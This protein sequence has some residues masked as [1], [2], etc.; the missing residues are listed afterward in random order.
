M[1]YLRQI[2]LFFSISI[3]WSESSVEYR[4]EVSWPEGM[5][6]GIQCETGEFDA[7]LSVSGKDGAAELSRIYFSSHML[8]IGPLVFSGSLKHLFCE[9]S[10]FFS[11]E[12]R[13]GCL[14]DKEEN[15]SGNMGVAFSSKDRSAGLA[16]LR[17]E[18][19]SGLYLWF[20]PELLLEGTL[21]FGQSLT[22]PEDM[23]RDESWY[24]AE[25]ALYSP[26]ISNSQFILVLG[27]P[28]LYGG[29]ELIIN[30][31]LFDKGGFSLRLIGGRAGPFWEIRS[32]VR[33]TSSLFFY[34]DGE[35]VKSPFQWK[36][37]LTFPGLP[38]SLDYRFTVQAERAG[39]PWDR[40]G[41][42][43]AGETTLGFNP[44]FGK[45]D[46]RWFWMLERAD[47]SFSIGKISVGFTYDTSSE[48]FGLQ[49]RGKAA[50]EEGIY[51]YIIDLAGLIESRPVSGH[52]GCS[53]EIDRRVKLNGSAGV[54]WSGERCA[55][56]GSAAFEDLV[57]Y[58][59]GKLELKP[60]F[61]LEFRLKR[62]FPEP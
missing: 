57:I 4:H 33:I 40:R 9:N 25:P 14:I 30:T 17:K 16:A 15:F 1:K 49:V 7:A 47:E 45:V 13:S 3:A 5:A 20:E 21:S 26:F 36:S 12:D 54:I 19:F 53:L 35:P 52:L 41:L 62:I 2:I 8:S 27:D 42:G 43:I 28:E 24:L 37:F 50:L 34:A 39:L 18:S 56:K 10:G 61:S 60:S 31:A 51:R 11:F 58:N 46:W 6:M 29:G 48:P 55:I 38:F 22:F 44:S 23:E 32:E 59:R